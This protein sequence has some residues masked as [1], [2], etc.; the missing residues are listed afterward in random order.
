MAKRITVAEVDAMMTPQD[1]RP[2]GYRAYESGL[3]KQQEIDA[4]LG[5]RPL[6]L[7]PAGEVVEAPKHGVL[8]ETPANPLNLLELPDT[9]E[10]RRK[11]GYR[12]MQTPHAPG[13]VQLRVKGDTPEQR[14]A[15][16]LQMAMQSIKGD[17]A[18]SRSEKRGFLSALP[19]IGPIFDPFDAHFARKAT[20]RVLENPDAA[21]QSDYE[22]VAWLIFDAER[23]EQMKKLDGGERFMLKVAEIAAQLPG[24]A[25]EFGL[26]G[27]AYTVGKTVGRKVVG[28]A[29]KDATMR[30]LESRLLAGG[31]GA[32][33]H[34]LANPQR[35]AQAA[36]H[37]SRP[38]AQFD[39]GKLHIVVPDDDFIEALP[40]AAVRT[41]ID[42]ATERAGGLLDEIP[43]PQWVRGLKEALIGRWLAKHPNATLDDLLSQ[44]QKRGGWHGAAPEVFE[45]ELADLALFAAGLQGAEETIPTLEDLAAEFV[46]FSIPGVSAQMARELSDRAPGIV[47]RL[48]EPPPAEEAAPPATETEAK[49][50]AGER[51]VTDRKAH[52]LTELGAREFADMNPDLAASIVAEFEEKGIVS[53]RGAFAQ[54]A[55]RTPGAQRWSAA[56]RKQFAEQLQG[57]IA[58]LNAQ[59]QE[60]GAVEE[61]THAEEIRADAGQV[62]ESGPVG[63]G[64]QTE[65]GENLQRQPEAGPEARVEEVPQEEVAVKYAPQQLWEMTKTE[66]G[67]WDIVTGQSS[68]A[69]DGP[70]PQEGD[71]RIDSFGDVEQLRRVKIADLTFGESTTDPSIAADVAKYAQW[72]REGRRPFPPSVVENVSGEVAVPRTINRR[73]V[74][75]AIAAG[76]TEMLVWYSETTPSGLA[77]HNHK[78]I[79]DA[80]AAAG[81]IDWT[82][83]LGKQHA[84]DYPDLAEK[85]AKST[86]EQT[87]IGDFK[88]SPY[89][90]AVLVTGPTLAIAEKLKAAGGRW[91]AGKNGFVFPAGQRGE[92]EKLLRDESATTAE[93]LQVEAD[94]APEA[95]PMYS[96]VP[97]PLPRTPVRPDTVPEWS[98][99]LPEQVLANMEV[100]KRGMP[101]KTA[102]EKIVEFFATAG[103]KLTRHFEHLPSTGEYDVASAVLRVVETAAEA[104]TDE[105]NRTIA[106]IIDPLGPKR[107][108]LFRDKVAAR[109]MVESVKRGEPLPMGFEKLEQIEQWEADIDSAIERTAD[110]DGRNRVKEALDNRRRVVSELVDDLVAHD[111]LTDEAGK[112]SDSYFHQQVLGRAALAHHFGQTLR[113]KKHSF[114]KARVTGPEFQ[115]WLYN[116]DYIQ[117]EGEWIR[118]AK[119]ELR[120]QKYLRQLMGHYDIKAQLKRQAFNR[121]YEALVGGPENMRRIIELRG[122]IAEARE[123]G[124]DKAV[125]AVMAEELA[126][127]DPTE[128]FRARIA[129]T[130]ATLR[131][132]PKA[133]SEDYADDSI[134]EADVDAAW[135]GFVKRMAESDDPANEKARVAARA[136]FN[137]IRGRQKL[138]EERLGDKLQTWQDVLRERPE[139]TDW[140]PEP[141]NVFYRALA[142]PE[143]LAEALEK[144]L[145]ETLQLTADQLRVV[146][147]LGGRR[148]SYVIPTPLA[149]QLTAMDKAKESHAVARFVNAAHRIWKTNALFNPTHLLGYTVRNAVGDLDGVTGAMATGMLRYGQRASAEVWSYQLR[150]NLSMS[151]DLRAARDLNVIGSSLTATETSDLSELMPFERFYAAPT[152]GRLAAR[153]ATAPWRYGRALNEYRENTQR[154]MAY[155][156]YKEQLQNGTLAHY[157]AS[158][159]R[160]VDNIH[161]YLGVEQAAAHLARNALGDYGAVTVFGQWMAKYAWSFYRWAEVN[162]KRYPRLA[163]NGWEYAKVKGGNAAFLRGVYL[164]WAY[165]HMAAMVAAITAFNWMLFGDDEKELNERERAQPHILLGRWP[166]GTIRVMRN[167][168]ALGD[169][170]DWF[171]IPELVRLWPLVQANQLTASDLLGEMGRQV[172]TK[173][174]SGAAPHLKG[175]VE[176]G[177]GLSLYPDTVNPRRTPRDEALANTLTIRDEYL[178][179]KGL[180]RRDGTRA[181][182]GYFNR[183]FAGVSDPNRNAYAAA[184]ELRTAYLKKKGV[185]DEGQYPRSALHNLRQSVYNEDRE[186]FREARAVY[187]K[188]RTHADF[189]RHLRYLDPIDQ[190][191]SAADERDFETNFLTPDQRRTVNMARDWAF[192]ARTTLWQWWD[193]ESAGDR[194]WT[195]AKAKFLRSQRE[196]LR[197]GVAPR[198]FG[199]PAGAYRERLIESQ[200]SR[201]RARQNLRMTAGAAQSP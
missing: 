42:F 1:A 200:A 102:R 62:Q 195:K 96:G 197:R 100:A 104:E 97:I 47:K 25:F 26:T 136:M 129:W 137:A 54:V 90:Q 123:A 171:A 67:K 189:I 6:T 64:G 82:S 71:W 167:M 113:P 41:Y 162:G 95:K 160:T 190:K 11:Y 130:A 181:R 49:V 30:H 183:I 152:P 158:R 173:A 165:S 98:R 174:A 119:I 112:R 149:T 191:L 109:N 185:A 111:L 143:K 65:G 124:E 114:Q 177:L 194:E 24:F 116:L 73:R 34:M 69:Y 2:T 178:A 179:V 61:P 147:A 159:K 93:R 188:E 101:R 125:I 85:Y 134:E 51:L 132:H 120:K 128:P 122:M 22:Q 70:M 133:P 89:K 50:A 80:A 33:T 131:K 52:L 14:Q 76:E 79:V 15:D 180:I 175:L 115:T 198:K 35:I 37:L 139:Y 12:V 56:E 166:D 138:F 99:G 187:L 146:R 43:R 121:N 117:A 144:G 31:V 186:Q 81:K 168:S 4:L 161:K 29:L 199:E 40:E 75:G 145:L 3:R 192:M 201:E 127:L 110:E 9:P 8:Y 66:L 169:F 156:W 148:K 84:K 83:D 10:I 72:W 27:G 182:N 58:S 17:D 45:E 126:A 74:L 20:E 5:A 68:G 57:A 39:R 153:V 32:L 63:Q 94:V 59:D 170:L 18:I 135:W 176:V 28:K 105:T 46:A 164:G 157:G 7:D 107:L 106:A 87:D 77:K 150:G 196:A 172:A 36:G 118:D 60:A 55:E 53:S 19:F 140:Q 184:V 78:A 151:R 154:Y 108:E 48:G 13:M 21:S 91:L 44:V 155:L 163:L 103:R 16:R 141:G 92:V 88:L 23:Q 86:T 142:I 38:Q 193:E